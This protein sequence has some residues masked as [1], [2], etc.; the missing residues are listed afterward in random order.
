L[1]LFGQIIN[2]HNSKGMRKREGNPRELW[3][4]IKQIKR[5]LW[6]YKET[7]E[8]R[9]QNIPEEIMPG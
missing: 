6:E 5:T 3:D 9:G 8:R 2:G 4:T 7:G 1:K